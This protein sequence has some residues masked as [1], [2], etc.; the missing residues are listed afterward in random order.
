MRSMLVSF[1]AGRSIARD[2]TFGTLIFAPSQCQNNTFMG[3]KQVQ[4]GRALTAAVALPRGKLWNEAALSKTC[5]A[6]LGL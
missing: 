6:V 5:E 4:W 1:A 3:L 2:P